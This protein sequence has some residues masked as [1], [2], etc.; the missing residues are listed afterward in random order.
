M[1]RGKCES[2]ELKSALEIIELLYKL[3]EAVFK[4]FNDYSSIVFE[5]KHKA[6]YWKQLKILT[7]KQVL[8]RLLI[9]LA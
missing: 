1:S 9:A 5:A 3:R 6:R 2:E 7:P 4:L 8:Q